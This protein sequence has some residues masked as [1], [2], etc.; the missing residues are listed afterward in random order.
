MSRSKRTSKTGGFIIA[1]SLSMFK[2]LWMVLIFLPATL[3]AHGEQETRYD[4]IHLSA[5][6]TGSV[7]ND[8][9]V[10]TLSAQEE[11]KQASKLADKVN[12]RIRWGIELAKKYPQIKSQIQAY[13]TQPIYHKSNITGWRVSQTLK[14]ESHKMTEVSELLGELQSQLNL[15]GIRFSV[16]PEQQNDAENTLIAEALAAFNVRAKLIAG[17]LG[18]PN[19]RLVNMNVS[20][21]GSVPP[22]Y[23]GKSMRMEMMSSDVASPSLEAGE[24]KLTVTVNGEVELGTVN[25]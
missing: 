2:R 21:S 12:Q 19:F 25:K 23:R 16:S 10:A 7:E 4:Q 17:E 18:Q 11:G 20:T 6:A 22:P 24:S 15:Q 9:I 14:L 3:L 8:T 13:N 5:S 1:P